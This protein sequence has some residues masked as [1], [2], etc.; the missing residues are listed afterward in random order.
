MGLSIVTV[1]VLG[2]AL[3]ITLGLIGAIIVEVWLIVKLLTIF[4]KGKK[5]KV[6]GINYRI[7]RGVDL[8]TSELKGEENTAVM[9]AEDEGDE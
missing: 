2:V 9:D 8:E 3:I 1:V 6:V 5:E 7:T 4:V